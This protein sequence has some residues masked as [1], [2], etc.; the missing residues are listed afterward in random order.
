MRVGERYFP[1]LDTA[2]AAIA[3]GLEPRDV[4]PLTQTPEE[5][6]LLEAVDFGGKVRVPVDGAG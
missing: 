4:I 6:A 5:G 2:L 1:S 3:L